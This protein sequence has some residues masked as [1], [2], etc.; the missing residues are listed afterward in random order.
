M[1]GRTLY[2]GKYKIEPVEHYFLGNGAFGEVLKGRN[3]KTNEFVAIKR[4]IK[5]NL[6]TKKDRQYLDREI[7]IMVKIKRKELIKS[8]M[9]FL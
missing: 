5:K 8:M 9:T 1:V 4:I 2:K 6:R 7:R 3:T